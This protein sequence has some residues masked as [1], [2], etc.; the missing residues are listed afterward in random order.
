[1]GL[2]LRDL[3]ECGSLTVSE[4]ARALG[5]DKITLR[6]WPPDELPYVR[7]GPRRDRRYRVADVAA[8][9]DARRVGSERAEIGFRTFFVS[10][11]DRWSTSC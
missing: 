6:Q 7:V 3:D 5:V 8:Y 2:R 11:R 1:V 10:A 4:A 9:I